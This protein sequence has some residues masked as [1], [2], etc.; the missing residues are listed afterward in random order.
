MGEPVSC[1]VGGVPRQPSLCSARLCS[2]PHRRQLTILNDLADE[3]GDLDDGEGVDD[4]GDALAVGAEHAQLA[5]AHGALARALAVGRLVDVV[6]RVEALGRPVLQRDVVGRVGVARGRAAAHAH[7][8]AAVVGRILLLLRWWQVLLA[9]GAALVRAR[10]VHMVVEDGLERRQRRHALRRPVGRQVRLRRVR[11]RRRVV[12]AML[13][14]GVAVARVVVQRR[15]VRRRTGQRLA[16]VVVVGRHCCSPCH[17][18]PVRGAL[19]RHGV[20]LEM[21]RQQ[22]KQAVCLCVSVYLPASAAR[23][24]GVGGRSTRR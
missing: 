23:T 12:A 17:L 21:D 8:H 22:I 6:G 1:A 18:Q 24:D 11:A 3:D 13:V 20:V 7:A 5:E 19:L 2:S 14:V 10:R 4:E 16:V 9:R 15:R